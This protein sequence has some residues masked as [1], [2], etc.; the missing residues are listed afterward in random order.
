MKNKFKI[1]DRVKSNPKDVTLRQFD[2]GIIVKIDENDNEYPYYVEF[3][4]GDN[5]EFGAGI[6]P[7]YSAD[8]IIKINKDLV[9]KRLKIK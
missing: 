7:N 9:K 5:N 1:G 3:T 6:N 4:W 8:E 2:N